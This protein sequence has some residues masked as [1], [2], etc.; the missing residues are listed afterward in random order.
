[1]FS[2]PNE[3]TVGR[4]TRRFHPHPGARRQASG[5]ELGQR[6]AANHTVDNGGSP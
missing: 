3:A 2:G 1:M 4:A 5:L 6:T